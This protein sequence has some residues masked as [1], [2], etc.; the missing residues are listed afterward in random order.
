[1]FF[2]EIIFFSEEQVQKLNTATY[3]MKTAC[4]KG[5]KLDIC[6]SGIDVFIEQKLITSCAL[7]SLLADPNFLTADPGSDLIA[8]K[9]EY[10]KI[11]VP[12][13]DPRSQNGK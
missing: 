3:M 9:N 8:L 13:S 2:Y 5:T 12:D 4:K 10:L 7:A 1:M 6:I 11:T